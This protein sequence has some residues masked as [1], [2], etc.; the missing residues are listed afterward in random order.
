[1]TYRNLRPPVSKLER[2]ISQT[3]SDN[4]VIRTFS[5]DIK[6]VL[7]PTE[8]FGDLPDES[9]LRGRSTFDVA[10]YR[11]NTGDIT[12]SKGCKIVFRNLVY[13]VKVK[14]KDVQLLK[15]VTGRAQ[16][17]EMCALMGASGAGKS[18]LL[19]VLAGRKTTGRLEG[20][21]YFNGH[22]RTASVMRSASYVMQDNVHIGVLTVRQTLQFAASLR[23]DFK[24]SESARIKRIQKILDMLGLS[25]HADTVVGD[26]LIRGI[27]GGQLKRLSIGVEIINLPDM[28]FLDEPTTGLDSQISYE[29]M[30]AV[31]NLANQN[32]TVICTIHQPSPA[33]YYL[34]DKLLLMAA[35]KVIYFGPSKEVVKYFET[36]AY[37]FSYVKGSNPADYLIAVAGSFLPASNGKKISGEDLA[38][39]YTK[40]DYCRSFSENVEAMIALDGISGGGGEDNAENKGD[41]IYPTP[42]S[43]QIKVLLH[44][45]FLRMIKFPKTTMAMTIR[46]IVL[47]LFFGSLYYNLPSGLQ[48]DAYVNRMAL[49]FFVLLTNFVS[50]QEVIPTL[51]Y[52]RLL[53]YRER[54]AGAY[55]AIPYYLSAWMLR[56]PIYIINSAL[57]CCILY[58]L[59]GLQKERF[60]TFYLIVTLQS[61]ISSFLVQAVAALS[62]SAPAAISLFPIFMF[63]NVIFS[64]FII[65]LDDLP[66]FLQPWAAHFSFF[67]F[68]FQVRC[69]FIPF[70][71]I[72]LFSELTTL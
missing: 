30:S 56:V 72:Y 21:L 28:V 36:S 5:S 44:R 10:W 18:T 65:Y 63:P 33:T 35:G 13:S 46:N 17:G 39:H 64:G 26:E 19:D 48:P 45:S 14:G 52:D 59:T 38:L 68:A 58:E 23:M 67:R 47:A 25:D 22:T 51:F 6:E 42:T 11:T 40:S 49:F 27:S 24:Y 55:G 41:S 69:Y 34:F 70:S 20:E 29:V 61:L 54:G 3:G 71:S 12:S 57:Y 32:R 37:A 4:I 31:R 16:P 62:S 66:A 43:H 8:D 53:F 15:G 60:N 2:I 7:L 9:T 1:M 50:H